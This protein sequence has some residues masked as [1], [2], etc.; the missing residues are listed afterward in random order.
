MEDETILKTAENSKKH[1]RIAR[2]GRLNV[3]WHL[4]YVSNDKVNFLG[5]SDKKFGSKKGRKIIRYSTK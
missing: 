3:T 5:I 4:T 1:M 2:Q